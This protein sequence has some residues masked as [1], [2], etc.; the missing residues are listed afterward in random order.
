MTN[1]HPLLG[2]NDIFAYEEILS[3]IYCQKAQ[4]LLRSCSRLFG[5]LLS[6]KIKLICWGKQRSKFQTA[7]FFVRDEAPVTAAVLRDTTKCSLYFV[8]KTKRVAN[9][10]SAVNGNS[11]KPV[12]TSIITH[13]QSGKLHD[14]ATLLEALHRL[15]S[16]LRHARLIQ[17]CS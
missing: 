6:Y 3:E 11:S 15:L 9:F 16:T 14:Y 13:S 17:I 2:F 8:P 1:L 12:G 7:A 5:T 10:I 4:G